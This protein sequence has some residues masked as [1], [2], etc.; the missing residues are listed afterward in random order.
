M[1]KLKPNYNICKIASSTQGRSVSIE[2]RKQ[3]S[4]K[5]TGRILSKKTKLKIS[6]SLKGRT[7]P[8]LGVNMPQHTKDKISKSLKKVSKRGEDHHTYGIKWSES[9]KKRINY[10]K[11]NNPNYTKLNKKAIIDIIQLRKVGISLVE[12][13]AKY[14]ICYNK[15]KN[16]L[17][18][19]GEI[20]VRK[21]TARPIKCITTGENFESIVKASLSLKIDRGSISKVLNGFKKTVKELEF[22]YD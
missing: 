17:I 16:V 21:T 18:E 8:T 12:I 7:S 22:V 9:R 11:E 20:F 19:N 6:K 10:E 13:G 5:L 4:S 1:D 14:K 3:I 15:V 2:T